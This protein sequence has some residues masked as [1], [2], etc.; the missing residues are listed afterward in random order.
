ML[1]SMAQQQ[2]ED[3]IGWIN[4]SDDDDEDPSTDG[5]PSRVSTSS[6]EKATG[7]LTGE[8]IT[9]SSPDSERA[10]P[11]VPSALK[12]PSAMLSGRPALKKS[13]SSR[14]VTSSAN[15]LFKQQSKYLKSSRSLVIINEEEEEEEGNRCLQSVSV[16][17]D[18][19]HDKLI[20]FRYLCGVPINEP[21]VQLFMV[22]LIMIN[23]MM[24]GIATFDWVREN[25]N[26]DDAFEICDTVFLVI[27]TIELG[28]QFAF[29]GFGILLDGWLVFDLIIITLSWSFSS[30]FGPFFSLVRVSKS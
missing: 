20:Q 13:T 18:T 16:A 11:R 26:I 23:A 2:V 19:V 1:A 29:F 28:M 3:N 25:P 9:H 30:S 8:T 10:P 22:S 24:M 27:F 4:S 21:N 17:H 15:G 14:K 5:V 6:V 12:P 7:V